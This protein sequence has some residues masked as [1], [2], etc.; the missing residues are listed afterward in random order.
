MPFELGKEVA[1]D[2][3][4]TGIE[5]HYP[6]RPLTVQRIAAGMLNDCWTKLLGVEEKESRDAREARRNISHPY[7]AMPSLMLIHHSEI[8]KAAQIMEPDLHASP[9][10]YTSKAYAR[11]ARTLLDKNVLQELEQPVH[12]SPYAMNRVLVHNEDTHFMLSLHPQENT[13]DAGVQLLYEQR[14]AALEHIGALVGPEAFADVKL[15][16][17]EHVIGLPVARIPVPVAEMFYEDP[18]DLPLWI[19]DNI[20]Y[21]VREAEEAGQPLAGLTANSIEL[22]ELPPPDEVK[23]AQSLS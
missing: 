5:G 6:A 23:L 19:R 22:P 16:Q 21:T 15:E 11:I 12:V 8:T 17:D 2:T 20:D 3:E 9:D 18:W 14:K 10:D 1:Y 4:E 13:T 7:A